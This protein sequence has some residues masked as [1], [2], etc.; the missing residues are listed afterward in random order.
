MKLH[1]VTVGQP[2]LAYA[3][4]GFD[5][6]IKRL[7]RYL[8]VRVTHIADK[9][10]YDTRKFLEAV[11]DAHLVA[12]VIEGQQMNSQELAAF[13]QARELDGSDLCFCVGGPD[14]LPPAVIDKAHYRW[15]LSQ[16]TLPHDLAMVVLAET[17][18]RASTIN[19]GTP[20]HH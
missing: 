7:G 10:V 3:K 8:H 20:Y 12:L 16:L 15:S 1:I 11:G 4:L 18:Y 9:H 6:Y 13:M 14:G 5:E 17:L 2:K 19:A